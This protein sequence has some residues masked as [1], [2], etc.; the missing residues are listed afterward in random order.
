MRSLAPLLIAAIVLPAEAAWTPPP[1][2]DPQKILR[3]A[4]QDREAGQFADSLAKLVWFHEHALEYN[5]NLSGIRRTSALADWRLLN[6]RYGAA[7]EKLRS[8]RD[9]ST[10]DVL[11]GG[12]TARQSF[13]D[14]AAINETLDEEERTRELFVKLDASNPALARDVYLRAQPI[15]VRS[16]DYVLCGRYIDPKES[17]EYL[18]TSYRAGARYA[19]RSLGGDVDLAQMQFT[20][21][22]T[23][24]AALLARNQRN[25]EARKFADEAL[26]VVDTPRFHADLQAAL[27]GEIPDLGPSE[28][29]RSL[30]RALERAGA[31]LGF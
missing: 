2:P 25:A 8:I 5:E 19:R 12:K 6:Y 14:V 24:A 17:L 3:E 4:R 31:Y 21:E 10:R 26:K 15:L 27:Q 30:S 29:M 9:A 18:T 23:L 7:R 28:S 16:G 1:N 20:S 22:A 11:T 13:I